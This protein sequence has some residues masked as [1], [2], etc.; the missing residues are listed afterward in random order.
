VP[1]VPTFAGRLLATATRVAVG[2]TDTHVFVHAGPWTFA[3]PSD[4]AARYPEVRDVTP[5][6][7]SGSG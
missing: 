7:R 2:R 3:L 1:A 5:P 4:A 6:G